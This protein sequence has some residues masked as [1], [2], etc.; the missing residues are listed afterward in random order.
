MGFI[1]LLKT[2][3]EAA[4]E[5][6]SLNR[7]VIELKGLIARIMKQYRDFGK[8]SPSLITEASA[9]LPEIPYEFRNMC[10]ERGISL[11]DVD[12]VPIWDYVT[13]VESYNRINAKYLELIEKTDEKKDDSINGENKE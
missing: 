4:K 3:F 5:N 1:D 13:L 8:L 9:V 11:N 2:K 12:V 6:E 7:E 10:D